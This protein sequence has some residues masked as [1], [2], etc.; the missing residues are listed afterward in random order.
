MLMTHL[1]SGICSQRWR[2]RGAILTETVPA[3]IM[4]SAWRGLA[5]KTSEP[6]R[7]R[8]YC[9]AEAAAIISK[10]QQASAYINGQMERERTQF[11]AHWTMSATLVNTAGS[12]C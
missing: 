9:G 1:G 5:R 6:K 4:R 2:R 3:T 10:P 12:S 8:S 11:C 7:E